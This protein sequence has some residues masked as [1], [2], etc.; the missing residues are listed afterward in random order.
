MDSSAT[1]PLFSRLRSLPAHWRMAGW[2][3]GIIAVLSLCVLVGCKNPNTGLTLPRQGGPVPVNLPRQ[4]TPAERAYWEQLAPARVIY[5]G[6]THNNNADHEYQLD[7]IKGLQARGVRFAVAWE[8]FDFTQQPLLDQWFA[9]HLGTDALLQKTDFQNHWGGLSVFYEKIM[10]WTLLESVPSLAINAPPSMSRKLAQN[11]PLDANE[12]AMLPSGFQPVP[13]GY[14]NFCEQMARHPHGGASMEN[15][16]KAQL[17]WDQTMASRIVDAL[18]AKPDRKL[19]VLVGRGHV[20][21]GFG[22]PAFVK[23]KTDAAQL[24]IFPGGAAGDTARGAIAWLQIDS[25]KH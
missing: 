17:L 6:E 9:H 7:V 19:V 25:P 11:V 14:E 2:R 4:E 5:I 8:M 1:F 3:T 24:V 15:L 16:Y 23:Q 21:G 12:Q 20:E 22:V 10:R 13:G 18:A